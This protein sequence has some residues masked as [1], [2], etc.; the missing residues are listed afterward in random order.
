MYRK[1]TA[2][3]QD[4]EDD[5]NPSCRI[6]HL[7][8]MALNNGTPPIA[9]DSFKIIEASGELSNCVK[10]IWVRITYIYSLHHSLC[11]LTPTI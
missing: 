9:D 3:K 4:R 1:G 10:L 2:I 7:M 8:N 5:E 11:A 6:T